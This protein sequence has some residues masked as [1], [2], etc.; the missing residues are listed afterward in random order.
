[1]GSND[2]TQDTERRPKFLGMLRR[3]EL[4]SIEIDQEVSS[5]RLPNVIGVV[6]SVTAGQPILVG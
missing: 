2:T 4:K 5:T 1:M 3:L 6:I